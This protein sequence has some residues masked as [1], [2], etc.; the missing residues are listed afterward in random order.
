MRFE[1]G[2]WDAGLRAVFVATERLTSGGLETGAL[3][4]GALETE[5]AVEAV[6]LRTG[7][8]RWRTP[9]PGLPVAV[10]GAHVAVA[11]WHHGESFLTLS[12]LDSG[13]GGIGTRHVLPLPTWTALPGADVAVEA[14][15]EEGGAVSVL[16]HGMSAY[17]G[18]A[19]PP[20]WVV[21]D[22]KRDERGGFVLGP[23][24]GSAKTVSAALLPSPP[25][26]PAP[27]SPLGD[28]VQLTLHLEPSEAHPPGSATLTL[29]ASDS[30]NAAVLWRHHLRD[31]IWQPPPPPP[32]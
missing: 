27:S 4:T 16:W 32:P 26:P 22:Q 21:D 18:G 10:L 8:V 19:P 12:L 3:E 11:H 9:C 1:G 25:P 14:V 5:A 24:A 30:R 7:D 23:A 20:Q 29:K 13:T 31:V 6:D 28:D 15:W 17:A 2:V